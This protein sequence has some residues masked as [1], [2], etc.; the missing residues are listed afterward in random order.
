MQAKGRIVRM[1]SVEGVTLRSRSHN[2]VRVIKSRKLR[3]EANIKIDPKEI[4]VSMRNWAQ[5]EDY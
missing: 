2:I 1:G 4:G 3:W 5:D